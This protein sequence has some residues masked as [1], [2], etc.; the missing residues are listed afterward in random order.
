[1]AGNQSS[2]SPFGTCT[3]N[4]TWRLSG[5]QW[6]PTG[7]GPFNEPQVICK[8]A[9]RFKTQNGEI[10]GDIVGLTKAQQDKLKQK[11]PGAFVQISDVEGT[12]RSVPDGTVIDLT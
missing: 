4:C 3:G 8:C 6:F 5:G 1:M 9:T 12:L 10:Q 2:Q 7:G 11:F